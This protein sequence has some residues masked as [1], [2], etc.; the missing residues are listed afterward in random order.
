MDPGEA[1]K[2]GGKAKRRLTVLQ[3]ILKKLD[4]DPEAL[5]AIGE[6]FVAKLLEGD[7]AA[8]GKVFDREDGPVGQSINANIAV[9]RTILLGSEDTL[10]H[11]PELPQPE[12]TDPPTPELES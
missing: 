9:Q 3:T 10:E 8:F 2:I 7:Q 12:S 4:D 11:A 5:R 1:G 6:A